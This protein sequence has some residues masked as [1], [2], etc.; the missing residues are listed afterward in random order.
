MKT[1]FDIIV[2]LLDGTV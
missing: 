1:E 2:L